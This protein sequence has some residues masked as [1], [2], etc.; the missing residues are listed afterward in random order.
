LSPERLEEAARRSIE[1]N[2]AN[3]IETRAVSRSPIGRRGGPGRLAV[4]VG[5][6]WPATGVRLSVQFLDS[7]SKT[8]R[9]RI[10][11][12]MNAWGQSA[13]VVFTETRGT[14][15][16]RIARLDSPPEEAGYW[17]YIGTEILTIPTGEPTFNLEGFTLRTAESEFRRVVRH[18]TGHT[19]GFEHEHLRRELIARIDRKKAIAYFDWSQG[20]PAEETKAQVL[21]PLSK[22]SILGTTEADPLSIMCYEIPGGITK[23]GKPIRGGSDIS[24]KDSAFAAKLYPKRRAEAPAPPEAAGTAQMPAPAPAGAP[25]LAEPWNGVDTFHLLVLDASTPDNSQGSAPRSALLLAS[26]GGA[27]VTAPLRLRASEKEPKTRFGKIIATH[28]RILDYTDREKG[29]LPNDEQMIAFGIDLFETLLSGDVRR[30]YDEA[31]SRQGSRKLDLVLTSMIPWIAEKPWEFAYDAARQ[32]F[33]ATEEIHFVRNVLTAVPSEVIAPKPLPLRML[34]ASAQPVGFGRLS[35]DQ[36]VAIIRRGFEPLVEAGLLAVEI[37]PRATPASLHARLLGETFEIVHFIGH[38]GFDDAAQEGFLVFQN[39]RGGEQLLSVRSAREI[40]CQRGVRLV[41][42]NSCL[43]GRGSR[44]DFNKGVAQ[45][46]VAR[47]IPALVANQYS[48]LDSSATS[49]AQHFYASLAQG[50]TLGQAAREA[51]IALNFA[52][53]GDPIDWAVPVV[54]ARD[55]AMRLAVRSDLPGARKAQVA[56]G[57]ARRLTP[58]RPLRIALWDIDQVFPTLDSI[59][60]RLNESQSVFGFELAALS[61]PLDVWDLETR[62]EDGS[63]YLWAERLAGRLARKPAELGVDLLACIT[64]HWMRDDAW[65]NLFGWWPDGHTPP[66]LVFSFAGFEELP[67]AGPLTDRAVANLAAATL[68]GYLGR[69]GSHER[70]PHTCPLAFEAARNLG[71]LTGRQRF[72][73]TCRARLEKSLPRELPALEQVLRAFD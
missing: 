12:H 31:R 1:V 9:S 22:A 26:Y 2:P 46:L 42:L 64:R 25:E 29:S 51:R 40:F 30:L 32:S 65:L 19:L 58:D 4:V 72:D 55:P 57:G 44:A 14:G 71:H 3:A 21:T 48:V 56:F 37:L 10:L 53:A 35:V 45:A 59:V 28:K 41:F 11:A 6:R 20:W 49:F 70:G 33:L 66:V 43:S 68:A 63:P 36:E 60:A 17:S 62:A 61:P 18:E 47:G 50:L 27:R 15:E 16:V 67:A 73:K 7:P 69:T 54:Y 5:N 52:M 34:V 24:P 38:G 8:L 13:S 39:D 23:D